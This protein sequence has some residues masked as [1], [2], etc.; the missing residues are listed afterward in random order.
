MNKASFETQT[1]KTKQSEII[2]Q[3]VTKPEIP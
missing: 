3:A 2:I 1:A